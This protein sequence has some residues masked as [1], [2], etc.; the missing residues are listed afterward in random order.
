MSDSFLFSN[1][2]RNYILDSGFAMIVESIEI[3]IETT[4]VERRTTTKNNNHEIEP[5]TKA[6]LLY[7]WMLLY[8]LSLVH[9][10]SLNVIYVCGFLNKLHRR[11]FFFFF[12]SLLILLISFRL[13]EFFFSLYENREDIYMYS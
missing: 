12:N 1:R 9:H 11:Y 5:T 13:F 7:I 10:S 4:K 8:G 3:L 2:L 6:N